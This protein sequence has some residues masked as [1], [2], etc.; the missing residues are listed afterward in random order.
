MKKKVI[1]GKLYNVADKAYQIDSTMSNNALI[2]DNY[3]LPI[4][5]ANDSKPGVYGYSPNA[6]CVTIKEPQTEEEI[7]EYGMDGVIDLDSSR[8]ILE[9]SERATLVRKMEEDIMTN[10][11]DAFY[12]P[13]C[14]DDTPTM[15]GFKEAVNLKGVDISAYRSRF[16]QPNN[17]IR[18]MKRPSITLVKLIDMMNVFD[19]QGV[20]ILKDKDG[21]VNK[22]SKEIVIPLNEGSV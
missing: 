12:L 1:D 16:D 18:M 9:L 22:M 7:Q 5:G 2:Y 13:Y 3:V 20:L 11:G 10:T 21:C 8:S 19:I 14:E 15:R 17:D 4:R 6:M